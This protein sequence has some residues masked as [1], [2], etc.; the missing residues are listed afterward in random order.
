MSVDGSGAS[1]SCS[2][3]V[4]PGGLE[5]MRAEVDPALGNA[6]P[7]A[8]SMTPFG[9]GYGRCRGRRG[10]AVVGHQSRGARQVLPDVGV[11]FRSLVLV[12]VSP[13]NGNADFGESIASGQAEGVPHV[14]GVEDERDRAR[15]HDG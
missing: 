8:E 6:P 3:N 2:R 13:M 14:L 5:A 10:R 12:G 4:G 7:H 1:W 11:R 15:Q 9:V